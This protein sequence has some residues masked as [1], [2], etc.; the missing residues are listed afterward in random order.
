MLNEH[1]IK[2]YKHDG[3]PQ[4][5]MVNKPP[6]YMLFPELGIEAR[7]VAERLAKK[8]KEQAPFIPQHPLFL[9]DYV[10]MMYYGMRF[11]D[12]NGEEDL[13]KMRWYLDKLIA[14]YEN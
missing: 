12:K 11:M 2:D 5:D 6:H 8:I 1:D 7:D 13:K 9:S 4:P 10:Q 3:A 14:S